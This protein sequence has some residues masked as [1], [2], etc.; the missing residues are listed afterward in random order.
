MSLKTIVNR[1]KS[2][3]S[4]NVCFGMSSPL[5]DLQERQRKIFL[6]GMSKYAL[7]LYERNK[8][9]KNFTKLA[10][11]DPEDKSHDGLVKSLLNS[12]KI[13]DALD[14]NNIMELSENEKL[15][16]DLDL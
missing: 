9:I 7:N 1:L 4:Q 3:N 6:R 14:S 13:V 2:M 16:D 10:L 8:D 12:G 11:S 15:L 5:D